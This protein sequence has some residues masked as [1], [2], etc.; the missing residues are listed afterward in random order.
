MRDPCSRSLGWYYIAL[1]HIWPAGR[2]VEDLHPQMNNVCLLPKSPAGE[3]PPGDTV[4]KS[5]AARHTMPELGDFTT[6]WRVLALAGLAII[7]GS[8]SVGVA[9]V[10]LRLI[11]VITDLAYFGCFTC[12]GINI[13]QVA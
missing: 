9:W 10:L 2:P 12:H 11:M 13:G 3:K 7:V 4:P 8:I 6:D 1:R 5:R